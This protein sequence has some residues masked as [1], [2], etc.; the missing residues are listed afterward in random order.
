MPKPSA[1]SCWVAPSIVLIGLIA[2]MSAILAP[3]VASVNSGACCACCSDADDS[4]MST[5]K[6]HKKAK[7]TPETLAE[8]KRLKEIWIAYPNRPSQAEF[9]ATFG[10]GSQS[11]VTL[12]LN[13]K[14]PLSLKAAR[15]FAKGLGCHIADFSPRL[16]EEATQIAET[17]AQEPVYTGDDLAADEVELIAIWRQLGSAHKLKAITG[18]RA[19]IDQ[20]NRH[21]QTVQDVF[22][23]ETESNTHTRY[24]PR[25][26]QTGT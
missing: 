1:S 18:L 12:F 9:G 6:D 16:A 24:V 19:L 11:A 4:Q 25:T 23:A 17:I 20:V 26:K 8:S 2:F 21:A 10:I 13:G 15:G 5:E 7:V 22:A 3:L 14:T